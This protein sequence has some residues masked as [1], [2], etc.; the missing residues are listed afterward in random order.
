MHKS[1][2]WKKTYSEDPTVQDI[3]EETQAW[4]DDMVPRIPVLEDYK[5]RDMSPDDQRAFAV[6][7]KQVFLTI[8]LVGNMLMRFNQY[9]PPEKQ[10]KLVSPPKP[11]AKL[12]A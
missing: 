8:G 12:D 5:A 4:Y 2:A 1:S 9:L 10:S 7:L 3:K 6:M 11:K